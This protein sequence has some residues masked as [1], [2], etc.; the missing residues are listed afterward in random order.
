MLQAHLYEKNLTVLS[1]LSELPGQSNL[2]S[3]PLALNKNRLRQPVQPYS[4]KLADKKPIMKIGPKAYQVV[5]LEEDENK[6]ESYSYWDEMI[7]G[8]WFIDSF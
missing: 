8:T 2:A 4:L 1:K 3:Y 7:L 5:P 6:F